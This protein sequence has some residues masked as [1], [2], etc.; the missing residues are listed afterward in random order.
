LNGW[1]AGDRASEQSAGMAG[2]R[3]ALVAPDET[4]I[5]AAGLGALDGGCLD[6]AI[7]RGHAEAAAHSAREFAIGIP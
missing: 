1:T 2:I 6:Q 5:A 3:R 4:E 7:L